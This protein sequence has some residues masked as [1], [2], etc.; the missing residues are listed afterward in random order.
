MRRHDV[1][2]VFLNGDLSYANG[3]LAAWHFYLSM[4]N[5]FAGNISWMSTVGNHESDSKTPSALVLPYN[6]ADS[7]GEC[8]VVA[9][10]LFPFP[11]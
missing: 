1:D 10:T 2:A 5:M 6:G 11:R 4:L 9:T 8:S 7:G 3:Y